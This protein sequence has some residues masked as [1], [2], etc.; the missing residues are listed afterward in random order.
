MVQGANSTFQPY[1]QILPEEHDCLLA[2]IPA[3]AE[4]LKG[5][6]ALPC[7]VALSSTASGIVG[8]RSGSQKL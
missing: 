1:L 5:S 3:E 6:P 2:W 7:A 4:Q 8:R